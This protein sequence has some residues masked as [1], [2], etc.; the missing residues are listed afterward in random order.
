LAPIN[1]QGEDVAKHQQHKRCAQGLAAVEFVLV[2]P[3]LLLMLAFPLYFGRYC[4][5]YSV[6]HAAATSAANYMSRVP[7]AE[8]TN[9]SK[10]SAAF[11][12]AREIFQEMTNELNPG[13]LRPVLMIDCVD[14]LCTGSIKPRQVRATVELSVEDLFF[15]DVTQLSLPIHVS[16][17]LPYRGR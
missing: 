17:T 8:A 9:T 13:P 1:F 11:G 4:Y 6:A 15:R 5:H 16:V 3:L 10:A 12:V 7:L 2:L 14:N